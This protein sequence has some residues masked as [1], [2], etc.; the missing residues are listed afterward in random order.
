MV[1]LHNLAVDGKKKSKGVFRDRGVIDARAECDGYFQC[2]CSGD[3]HLVQADTIFGNDLKTGERLLKHSARDGVVPTKKGVKIASE[4]K[5]PFLGQRSALSD[6]LKSFV[7]QHIMV[8]AGCV[9]KRGGGKEDF[10]KAA[11]RRSSGSPFGQN[12]LFVMFSSRAAFQ[13]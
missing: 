7:S 12:L 10:H 13:K 11:V 9:L 8:G 4:F 6:D 5:H 3:I 1:L 2:C